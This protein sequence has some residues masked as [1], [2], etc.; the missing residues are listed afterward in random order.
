MEPH[1]GHTAEALP[2][3]D[4]NQRQR[5]TVQGMGRIDD[6]DH[7]HGEVRGGNGATYGCI[8]FGVSS[9]FSAE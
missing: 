8:L 2:G 1:D 3:G 4:A 6:L 5:L 7:V 9:T